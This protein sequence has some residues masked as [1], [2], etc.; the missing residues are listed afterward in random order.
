MEDRLR[1]TTQQQKN[2]ERDTLGLSGEEEE[3]GNGRKKSA[4]QGNERGREEGGAGENEN[5]GNKK[6]Y[7]LIAGW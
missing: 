2:E 5:K 1:D 6:K 7:M 3:K 4:G